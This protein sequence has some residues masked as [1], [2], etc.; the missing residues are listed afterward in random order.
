MKFKDL[1]PNEIVTNNE[2]VTKNIHKNGRF[3]ECAICKIKTD[4]YNQQLEIRFCSEECQYTYENLKE[5]EIIINDS[6]MEIKD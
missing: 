2:T 1:Y 4:W 6:I 5:N 3:Y